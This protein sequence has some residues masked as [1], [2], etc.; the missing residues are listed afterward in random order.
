MDE[1]GPLAVAR[2]REGAL[3]WV[4]RYI[5]GKDYFY[6][7]NEADGPSTGTPFRHR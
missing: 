5:G 7:L 3:V 6:L 1:S 4:T 2:L